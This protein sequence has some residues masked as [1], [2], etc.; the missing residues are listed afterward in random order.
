ML[1]SRPEPSSPRRPSPMALPADDSLLLLH[2]PRCSKSR[3][4]AA[5]LEARG[6]E[7]G[8]R[9][10]LEQPLGRAELLDLETRLAR[11][12]AEVLRTKETAYSASGLGPSS[13]RTAVLSAL[14]AHPELLERPIL[15]RGAR[16]AV[17]RPIEAALALLEG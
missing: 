1:W 9:R 4:L 15:V 8:V 13:S 11:P 7:Y 10:Y 6:V 12:L 2:N 14:L 17:G 16:A 5:E 3:E